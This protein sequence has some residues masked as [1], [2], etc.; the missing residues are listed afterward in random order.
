[1]AMEL[2]EK[3]NIGQDYTEVVMHVVMDNLKLVGIKGW[4]RS[5]EKGYPVK[6]AHN[7]GKGKS[8]FFLFCKGFEVRLWGV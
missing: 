7:E 4:D 2:Q 6:G 8:Y 1:M 3:Q 5:K